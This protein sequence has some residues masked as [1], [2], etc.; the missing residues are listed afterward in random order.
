MSELILPSVFP[1]NEQR[2]IVVPCDYWR[3]I[4]GSPVSRSL[5]LVSRKTGYS[6][7]WQSRS[8]KSLLLSISIINIVCWSMK[9]S[10][11][12]RLTI[13]KFILAKL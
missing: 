13:P 4:S 2:T 12:V 8:A 1:M 5:P 7:I 9:R 10:S 11:S 3:N 6:S